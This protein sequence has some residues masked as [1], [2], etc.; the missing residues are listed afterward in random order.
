MYLL[1]WDGMGW[2]FT[3]QNICNG[4]VLEVVSQLAYSFKFSSFHDILFGGS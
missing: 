3:I 4:A 2:D 1:G